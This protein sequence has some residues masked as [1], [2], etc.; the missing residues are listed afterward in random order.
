[1]IIRVIVVVAAVAV[2]G[3][4]TGTPTV[5]A[6]DTGV[7]PVGIRA[8]ALLTVDAMVGD[9]VDGDY[10]QRGEGYDWVSISIVKIHDRGAYVKARS[11]SDKKRGTCTFDG[12]GFL[13]K[14][15]LLAV[16][17]DGKT[18]FFALDGDRLTVQTESEDDA[19][20]L[21]FFCS[22]GATLAGEYQKLD[23]SLDTSQLAPVAFERALSL[24]G[25]TFEVQATNDI[26][27]TL[28]IQ[29]SGLEI[30][31]RLLVHQFEGE[32][33]NAEIEDLNSDGWPELL[34]YTRS[35]DPEQRGDVIAYST[36]NGKSVSQV[37]LADPRPQSRAN[38][39]YMGHDEF[40]LS[41]SGRL[42]RRFPVYN[43]ETGEPTGMMREIRY[44]LV[45]GEASRIFRVIAVVEYDPAIRRVSSP[46]GSG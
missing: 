6:Q 29:P 41:A 22:G 8:E 36:N 11:R 20:L 34:V 18:I 2:I 44:Q 16:D 45:D 1:M 7:G 25:V 23:E 21:Y 4:A 30:D 28:T 33:I 27:N 17:F 9:Y 15:F 32:V 5:V 39:G 46:P 19:D 40:V 14:E 13:R 26:R 35:R 37:Y 38:V 31:N 3:C 43:E 42:F 12:V 10:A 24:Q